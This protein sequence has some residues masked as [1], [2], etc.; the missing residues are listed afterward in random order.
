MN[1]FKLENLFSISWMMSK[2]VSFNF[3]VE[4]QSLGNG[5]PKLGSWRK[6]QDLTS[7]KEFWYCRGLNPGQVD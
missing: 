1:E 7:L 3:S 4:F 5:V 6:L 2:F